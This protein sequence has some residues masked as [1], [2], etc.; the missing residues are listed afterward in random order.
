MGLTV[1]IIALVLQ[2]NYRPYRLDSINQVELRSLIIIT[3]TLLVFPIYDPENGAADWVQLMVTV[4]LLIANAAH[5][6]VLMVWIVKE[7]RHPSEILEVMESKRISLETEDPLTESPLQELNFEMQV[8]K[9]TR[10]SAS[11]TKANM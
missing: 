5:V 9:T 11:P 10:D 8:A 7:M 1:A 2:T 4:V 3:A 6:I